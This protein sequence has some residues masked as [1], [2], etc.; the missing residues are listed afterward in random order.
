MT[1]R[2]LIVSHPNEYSQKF[3]SYPFAVKLDKCLGSFNALN[4]V[5]ILLMK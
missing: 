1:Q 3:H 2:T 4:E 5:I